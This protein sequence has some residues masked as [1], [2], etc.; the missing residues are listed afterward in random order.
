VKATT[1]R[2]KA[3]DT[4]RH[5]TA[6][7]GHVSVAIDGAA[8]LNPAGPRRQRAGSRPASISGGLVGRSVP[9][10]IGPGSLL[11]PLAERRQ[12]ESPACAHPAVPFICWAAWSPLVYSGPPPNLR[13]RQLCSAISTGVQLRLR[14][15]LRR[16][17]VHPLCCCCQS[18]DNCPPVSARV[19]THP[20][21]VAQHQPS[22]HAQ[23]RLHNTCI[24][25]ALDSRRPVPA[26]A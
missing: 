24:D 7:P 13:Y 19:S 25:S 11:C 14:L 23:L 1:A 6:S 8:A 9:R 3:V 2:W 5:T 20:S 18:R 16:V 12:P 15:R 21:A 10:V 4:Q 22:A 17:S 26:S